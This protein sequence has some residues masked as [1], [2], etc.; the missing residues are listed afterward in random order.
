M[1]GPWPTGGLLSQK[2]ER[3]KER[4]KEKKDEMRKVDLI[5]R[6]PCVEYLSEGAPDYTFPFF[7]LQHP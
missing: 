2:K 3:K 4:K 5:P 1:R 6:H 7:F